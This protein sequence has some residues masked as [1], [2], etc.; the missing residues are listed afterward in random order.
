MPS[1][2][3]PTASTSSP[4]LWRVATS[5]V[6]LYYNTLSTR[7][8][9]LHRFYARESVLSRLEPHEAMGKL[10]DEPST[11]LIIGQLVR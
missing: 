3:D 1:A 2:A 5:F 9:D 6:E 8:V 7:P 11:N 10:K 4:S